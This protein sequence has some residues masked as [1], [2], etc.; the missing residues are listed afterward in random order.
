MKTYSREEFFVIPD[1]PLWVQYGRQ[2][3]MTPEHN[4]DFIEIVF[5][6]QGYAVHHIASRGGRQTYGLI[7]GDVFSVMPDELHGYADGRN[8]EIYNI[9]LTRE[10]ISTELAGLDEINSWNTVLEH[11]GGKIHLPLNDRKAAENCLKRIIHECSLCKPGFKLYAKTAMIEFLLI[12][13]RVSPTAHQASVETAGG[14]LE[15]IRLMEKSPEKAMSLAYLARN[16]SM[17]VSHYTKKFREATG[18]SPLS[19]LINLRLEKARG[20]LEET[21]LPVAEIAVQCGFCDSNY[22]IKHFRL[23]HGITPARYRSLLHR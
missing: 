13:G 7:Q 11:R 10:F 3:G 12:A 21:D 16:A 4:H 2:Q 1:L 23:R 9:G 20:L 19:Y 18:T 6:A 8:M 22:M 15:T 17:S 14:I 5:M